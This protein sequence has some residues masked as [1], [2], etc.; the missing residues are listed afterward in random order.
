[1][2]YKNSNHL[3]TTCG[4]RLTL[5]PGRKNFKWN[6]GNS[7]V[8]W[9]PSYPTEIFDGKFSTKKTVLPFD[10]VTQE[11]KI[12]KPCIFYAIP[13]TVRN[14]EFLMTHL[15]KRFGDV[16]VIFNVPREHYS[17]FT[18]KKFSFYLNFQII[19][20]IN[21][22]SPFKYVHYLSNFDPPLTHQS[23]QLIWLGFP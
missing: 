2:T 18:T 1:M 13:Y 7:N 12:E 5:N 17:H 8:F 16:S 4:T 6:F 15:L 19:Y 20:I 11:A 23:P 14:D 21:L 10:E 3:F 9:N 22:N